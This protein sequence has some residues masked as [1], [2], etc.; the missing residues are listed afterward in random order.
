MS[1]KKYIED[2]WVNPLWINL[3]KVIQLLKS[4][5][6]KEAKKMNIDILPEQWI[7]L[8]SL[9]QTDGLTQ[10]EIAASN[11]KHTPSISRTLNHLVERELVIKKSPD[12]DRRKFKVC[13]TAKGRTLVEQ[14]Y[15]KVLEVRQT[16]WDGLNKKDFDHFIHILQKM[17]ENLK[18]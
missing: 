12:S 15:P 7:I 4:E 5:F 11:F 17:Q 1:K 6:T 13:L 2:N 14:L 8:Y 18:S 9:Y 16:S 3:N 10:V